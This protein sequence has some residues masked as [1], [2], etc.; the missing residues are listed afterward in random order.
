[1]RKAQEEI[2]N[3]KD[4]IEKL[5]VEE[6]LDRMEYARQRRK[7]LMERFLRTDANDDEENEE[8]I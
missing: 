8:S 6:I 1:M 5:G 7:E 2:K 3:R 4:S